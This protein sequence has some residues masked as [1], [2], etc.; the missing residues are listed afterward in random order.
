MPRADLPTRLPTRDVADDVAESA[1]LPF[2]D[3]ICRFTTAARNRLRLATATTQRRDYREPLCS[4][5]PDVQPGGEGENMSKTGSRVADWLSGVAGGGESLAAWATLGYPTA[6]TGPNGRQL[7]EYIAQRGLDP[8]AQVGLGHTQL[9]SIVTD[10]RLLFAS[11]GGFAAI[12]PKAL[13]VDAPIES[14]HLEWWDK[15]EVGPNRRWLLFL[16]GDRWLRHVAAVTDRSNIEVFTAALGN[17][18]TK[19][20]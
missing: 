2:D 9:V 14:I 13:V 7:D 16:L 10:R 11:V 18:A 19:I 8:T 4:V 20:R 1:D 12:K 6:A 15:K 3:E 5:H 17:R